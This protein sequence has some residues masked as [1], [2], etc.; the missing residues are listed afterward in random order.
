MN[1]L[2][3]K[4]FTVICLI[5]TIFLVSILLIFNFQNYYKNVNNIKSN[6]MRMDVSKK[7]EPTRKPENNN[8]NSGP[9]NKP[10]EENPQQIFMDSTIYTVLLDENKNIK[11]VINHTTENISDDE[12]KSIAENIIENSNNE[13]LKIGN[14]YFTNY[15][16]AFNMNNTSLV[17][18]DNENVK[19]EL[20]NLLKVSILIFIILEVVIVISSNQ[21]TNWIIKPVEESFTRQKQFIQDAS[22]ELKT[23]LAVII[24]SSEALENNPNERKW[25]ENIKEEADGMNN[26][27]SD[28]L[29]M[30]KS[31]NKVQEQY[32]DENLSKLVEKSVLTFESLIYEKNIKL[33]YNIEEN[34][35]Y[36]NVKK[37]DFISIPAGTIH[38]ICG[39]IMLCEIQQSS[40]VT[41]RVYDWNRI[42]L[43]GKPRQLHTQKALDVINVNNNTKV[44]NY[45]NFKETQN[46]YNSKNFNIDLVNVKGNLTTHSNEESF[47]AYIVLEGSG[48]VKSNN[49][50]NDLQKGSTFLI[51]AELGAYAFE[52][53]L[54]LMK[55]YL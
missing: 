48:K 18:I 11:D 27:V 23:P 21:I 29:E 55:V 15:S 40:D 24:A 51:P 42:G 13:T 28:L 32:E 12:I 22:H 20:I 31:E 17:I 4:V 1:K 6:L 43:D 26:L 16:Y 3:N 19:T 10:D 49:F 38:A 30:A 45:Y 37:G 47:N 54:K 39:G 33:T 9:Q 53:N 50:E 34:V 5:L 36:V 44:H 25:L 41:Y 7:N 46:I 52:G 14:L 35:K 2:K 8:E